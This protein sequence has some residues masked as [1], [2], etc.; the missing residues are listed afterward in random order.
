MR[1]KALNNA[2]GAIKLLSINDARNIFGN[3]P[4]G[5]RDVVACKAE[6]EAQT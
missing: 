6:K 2:G 4:I 5:L 3:Q 1:S